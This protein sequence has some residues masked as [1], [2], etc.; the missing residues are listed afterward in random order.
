M[1][2][3]YFF[4]RI[5]AYI[6]DMLIVSFIVFLIGSVIPMNS[7][8]DTLQKEAI[9]LQEKYLNGEITSEEFIRQ[10]AYITYDIDHASVMEYIVEIVVM[11]FYFI[12]FQFYNRGQTLG[13]KLMGLRVVGIEG[14]ELTMNDYIY[15][16]MILNAIL[17]NILVV[18]LVL[19][20]NRDYY[21]YVVGPLQ[22]VQ[23]VVLLVTIFMVLFRK[24]GRGLHDMG[25]H[26]KV[27]MVQ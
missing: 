25:G 23:F 13:K 1:E 4:P 22:F 10:N 3:A 8:K 12:I 2:K 6:I 20:M 24:D 9:S 15:R 16:S 26:S 19:F 7:N 21:F 14:R 5:L 11:I 17:A 18:I 27:I